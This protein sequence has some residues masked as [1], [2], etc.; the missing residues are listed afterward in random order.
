MRRAEPG[1]FSDDD[2]SDLSTTQ[3][4]PKRIADRP[5]VHFASYGRKWGPT[6]FVEHI[7]E[8]GEIELAEALEGKRQA[9]TPLGSE[10]PSSTRALNT[11]SHCSRWT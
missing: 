9:P 10:S 6:R 5:G 8:G 3:Q 1:A 2:S 4:R 7:E 11:D